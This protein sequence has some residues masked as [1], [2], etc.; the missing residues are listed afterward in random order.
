MTTTLTDLTDFSGLRQQAGISIDELSGQSGFSVRQLYRYERGEGRPRK[1]VLHFLQEMIRN[2]RKP[3]PEKPSFT[4]IDLFAGI[5]GLRRG[6]E[7]LGGR[8]VFTSEWDEYAQKT[9]LANFACD[10]PING[11]ITKIEAAEIPTHDVL[12]AGFPCQPFSIAGVSKKNALNRPHGFRCETQGT[13]FFDVAR[14][15]KHHQPKAFRPG[16]RQESRQP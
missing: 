16:K 8:C 12:L 3:S 15:I 11:D 10:H 7:P 4:F 6:F 1:A 5:G 14:I 2:S 9:Y 13:L